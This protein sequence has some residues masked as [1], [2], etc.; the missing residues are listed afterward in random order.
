MEQGPDVIPIPGTKKAKYLEENLGSLRVVLSE[1]QAREIGRRWRV[2]RRVGIGIRGLW[3]RFVL[4]IRR[5]W[6]GEKE[7]GSENEG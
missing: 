7:G 1:G 6:R 2:V 3:R 5:S 4:E